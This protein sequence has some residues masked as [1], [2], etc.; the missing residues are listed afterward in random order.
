MRARRARIV[1]VGAAGLLGLALAAADAPAALRLLSPREDAVVARPPLLDW[2]KVAGATYYNVQLWRGNRKVLSRWP[3]RSRFQLHRT[4]RYHGRSFRLDPARYRWYVWPG[5][6]RGYGRSRGRAFV[7]GRPP[8]NTRRPVIAGEPREGLSLTASSGAWKGTKPMRIS[9]RWER[10][11]V[12][13]SC[14]VIPGATSA[15][16]L[17]GPADI[18][19][20]VRV[21]VTAT[22]LAGSRATPSA[23]TA[24]VLAARPIFVSGPALGGAFQQGRVVTV[25]PGMWQSSR[26]VTFSYRWLRCERGRLVCRKIG[27]A[28]GSGRLLGRADVEQRLRVI[29]RA[30]NSGGATEAA[31]AVSP[32]IGRVFLGTA[33]AD[34]LEG[35]FGADLLRGRAG[36]DR[37]RGG[38]GRDRLRGGSGADTLV[39]GNGGDVVVAR[40][41]DRDSVRCG[42]GDDVAVV[43]RRDRVSSD[44]ESVRVG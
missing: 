34:L 36:A 40:D 24:P 31:S 42:R 33:G 4:W 23:R 7:V 10:C 37:V 17:L 27:G 13:T 43:D 20:S 32:V 38:G 12:S 39:A 41:R 3:T 16:L 2:T 44:C 9:Y 18:D 22:N 14:A 11:G 15:T 5:F 35:T 25:T 21:V 8:V 28:T 26:P 29:V 6:P 1:V 19:S 30:E